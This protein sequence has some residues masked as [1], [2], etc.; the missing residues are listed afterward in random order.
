MPSAGAAAA[1]PRG[2]AV[3]AP[4]PSGRAPD[5]GAAGTAVLSGRAVADGAAGLDRLDG[6]S[7]EVALDG[8]DGAAGADRRADGLAGT[9][10]GADAA[11]N[12]RIGVA[13][14]TVDARLVVPLRP[15]DGDVA[16]D[17]VDGVAR[18]VAADV[19]ARCGLGVA[20]VSSPR[21]ARAAAR[22]RRT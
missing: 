7:G 22:R 2:V 4:V 9:D 5:D 8:V 12:R 11:T 14:P 16:P 15:A 6:A 18:R 1:A 10:V 13:A 21:A 19:S 20:V 3:G 17:G